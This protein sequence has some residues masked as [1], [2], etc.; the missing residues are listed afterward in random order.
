[1][2]VIKNN[3]H[4]LLVLPLTKEFH[5]TY[6]QDGFE[7]QWSYYDHTKL[8]I[9]ISDTTLFNEIQNHISTISIYQREPFKQG[10]A[11]HQ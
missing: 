11:S 1:M 2:R 10:S 6:K 8:Y 4:L 3:Y 7:V 9:K 5:L